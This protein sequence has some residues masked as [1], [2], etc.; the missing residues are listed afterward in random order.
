MR[1]L[2]SV[3]DPVSRLLFSDT[4]PAPSRAKTAVVRG[5]YLKDMQVWLEKVRTF[6]TVDSSI[7][8]PYYRD[9]H[10][11]MHHVEQ[12]LVTHA[13]DLAAMRQNFPHYQS[14]AEAALS[15][16]PA[17]DPDVMLPPQSPYQAYLRLL[18]VCGETRTRLQLF[19]PYLDSEVFDRYLPEVR[20]EV[21]ITLV[22]EIANMRKTRRRDR[23]VA[24][25]ELLAVERPKHYQ[26]MEVP[27]IHDRLLRSDHKIF[28][29]GGSP[30]DAS[31]RDFYTITE[32]DNNHTLHSNLDGIIAGS[33]PW[34]QVGMARHRRW[35][36]MCNQPRDVHP[37]GA[38]MACGG[39][40]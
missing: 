19:D 24:I 31:K 30:K 29:L 34:Y 38:C 6:C 10:N 35:C 37:A 16:I 13:D 3:L 9:I 25:S 15:D 33:V 23:I 14:Q 40:T 12:L 5:Q 2:G 17:D 18:A 22:T 4:D 11:P 20:K 36:S 1:E 21:E 28:H 7:L 8:E 39:Q 27:S 26:L 32:T